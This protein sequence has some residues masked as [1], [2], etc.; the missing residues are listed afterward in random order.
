[1][2]NWSDAHDW[3]DI[4]DHIWIGF[5]LIVIAAVPAWFARKAQQSSDKVAAQVVNGHQSPMRE[6]L[7]KA[8]KKIDDVADK[9]DS[10]DRKIGVLSDELADEEHRLANEEHRRRSGEDQIRDDFDRR[11]SDIISRLIK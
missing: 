1:M 7:D 5:V 11:V 8:I 4:I 6:D 10:L 2:T 3:F 9:V